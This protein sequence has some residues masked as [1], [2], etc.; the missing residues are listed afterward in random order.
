MLTVILRT[1]PRLGGGLATAFLVALPALAQPAVIRDTD[2]I[3]NITASGERIKVAGATVNI[4]GSAAEVK[5]AGASVVVRGEVGE[6]ALVAG[7]QVSVIGSVGGNLTAVGASI[8]IRGRV[9]NDVDA[10]GAVIVADIVAGG[11]VRLGGADVTVGPGSDIAGG[12]LVGGGTVTISGHVAGPIQVAG[13]VVTFKALTD[14]PVEIA[15]GKVII[16]AGARIGGDL[17]VRSPSEPAIDANAVIAGDTHRLDPPRW[18][19]PMS[20]WA[21]AAAF[22]AVV[23]AGTVLAG[24][25]L[26]LFGGRVFVTATD[27][28][29]LRPG[30]SFLI[31][32]LTVVLIPAIA[33]LLMATVVGITAGLAILFVMPLLIVFGHAVAA[34]GIV[35]AV[36]VRDRSPLGI[37]RAFVL[38]IVGAIIVALIW[39]IPWVGPLFALIV[40][41]LG[42]GAFARTLG[43]R[44]RRAEA[45]PA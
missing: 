10:G 25:V 32:V 21:W 39:L 20:P 4:V 37:V 34:A 3:V 14:G 42:T 41:L 16:D 15:G 30:S 28:V 33:V 27:H 5:A 17:T 12:L 31:G 19:W 35:S 13:G 29:R 6:D 11:R 40:L 43:A 22:A 45:A 8:E 18:S 9:G 24:I 26:L 7:A 44:L 23:A 1:I 38:L 36:F 2:A